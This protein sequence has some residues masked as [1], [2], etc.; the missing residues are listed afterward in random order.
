MVAVLSIPPISYS[1]HFCPF[2]LSFSCSC[3]SLSSTS[4]FSS[5]DRS[6]NSPALVLIYPPHSISKTPVATISTTKR[7]KKRPAKGKNYGTKTSLVSQRLAPTAKHD[8]PLPGGIPLAP[9]HRLSPF[10]SILPLSSSSSVVQPL[11]HLQVH[12]FGA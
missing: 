12:T 5:V 10:V 7:Q 9:L 8:K 6:R 1:S 11:Y 2:F 4:S 3:F